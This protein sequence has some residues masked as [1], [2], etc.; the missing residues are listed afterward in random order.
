MALATLVLSAALLCA[1]LLVWSA[2]SRGF[3]SPACSPG[4]SS[5]LSQQVHYHQ[6]DQRVQVVQV[7][8]NAAEPV[9]ARQPLELAEAL[10]PVWRVLPDGRVPEAIPGTST[11]GGEGRPRTRAGRPV[12]PDR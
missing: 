5:A 4:R 10:P 9:G 3:G 12:L 2:V 1:G 7:F 11:P 6:C 8:V